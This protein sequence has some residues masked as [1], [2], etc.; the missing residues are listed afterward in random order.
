MLMHS[1]VVCQLRM[2]GGRHY[3]IPLHQGGFSG[4]LRENLHARPGPFDDG[5][6]DKN[7][8]ERLVLQFR[9]SANH[10]ARDLPPVAITQY[11][12]VQ[13]FQGML[14]GI[15]AFRGKEYRPGACP[16][17]RATLLREFRNRV[18]KALFLE[19]L[20]L[21][22]ALA[23]RQ[24]Q[25][26]TTF[27]LIGRAHLYG[28]RTQTRQHRRMG[29]EVS[30]HGQNSTLHFI[31]SAFS[32]LPC[33]LLLAEFT[34]SRASTACPSLPFDERPIRA[35]LRPALREL[36]APPWRPRSGSLLSLRPSPA[37]RDR[38]T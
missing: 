34:T 24:N 37:P 1:G 12:H 8:F 3:L 31:H 4:V 33:P 16:K 17:D 23:P 6:A 7:H 21:C 15:L 18:R 30:L 14:P 13:Q 27:E 28:I 25:P 32:F 10:V 36:R 22:R 2:K 29:L 38:W 26:V 19:K 11:R 9:G 35:W 5:P 20:Q